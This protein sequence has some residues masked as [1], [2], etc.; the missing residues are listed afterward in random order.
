[1]KADL[2][3]NDPT[4]LKRMF[5]DVPWD[6]PEAKA[7]SEDVNHFMD[8]IQNL[9]EVRRA[10]GL[11]QSQVA[12]LMDTQQSCVSDFERIGGDPRIHTIMSYA[13]AIGYR[14]KLVLEKAPA[15]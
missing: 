15:E 11:T 14:A 7:I 2:M 1:M 3:D 4:G 8:F 6:S 13:R 5:P 9:R 12:E 10:E